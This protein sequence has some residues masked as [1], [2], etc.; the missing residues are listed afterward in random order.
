M[1]YNL[2][3]EHVILTQAEY[4][5]AAAFLYSLENDFSLSSNSCVFASNSSH[6]WV[7]S[8]MV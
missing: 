1:Y 3:T 4:Q 2:S 6:S 7:R 8:H 5:T